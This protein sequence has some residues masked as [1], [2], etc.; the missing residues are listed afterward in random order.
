M[1]AADTIAAGMGNADEHA[2]RCALCGRGVR[3][4]TRHHLI[5]RSRHRN[6]RTRRT[7]SR[8]DLHR[9]ASMCS[10]CHRQVHRTLTEKELERDYNTVEALRSHPEIE[11]FVRWIE[12]KPHGVASRSDGRRG[13][14]SER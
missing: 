4:L 9:T 11:K 3:H 12:R 2:E 14:T 10:S 8:E 5:P 7:F 13:R 1:P 6:K